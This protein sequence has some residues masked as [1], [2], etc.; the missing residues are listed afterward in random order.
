MTRARWWVA[1]LASAAVA[2]LVVAALLGPSRGAPTVGPVEQ[3][4]PVLPSASAVPVLPDGRGRAGSTTP[5]RLTIPAIG[6]STSLVRLG[7]Q[8]DGSVEVPGDPED[9]GWF[10]R[11]PVPGR[12]GSSVLLGHVDSV[13]GPAVFARLRELEHGARF[14]VELTSGRTV[15]FK[16]RIVRTYRNADFPAEKVYADHGHRSLNLVTCGG[17]YDPALGGYQSNVVVYAWRA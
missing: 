7:L 2:C 10:D 8:R 1:G 3:V 4:A 13:D 6:V 9:A 15:R 12:E 5:R 17:S 16:V 14:A 11:G